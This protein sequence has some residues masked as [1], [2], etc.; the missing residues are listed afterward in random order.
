MRTRAVFERVS[1]PV[2]GPSLGVDRYLELM[3]HDKKVA[4]GKLRLVLLERIG[5]AMVSDV[6]SESQ[7]ADTIARCV[8]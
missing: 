7:I 4:D 6:A 1:L 3:R 8:R 2:F 5:K